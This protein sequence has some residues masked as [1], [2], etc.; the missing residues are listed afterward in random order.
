MTM[1]LLI[2]SLATIFSIGIFKFEISQTAIEWAKLSIGLLLGHHA[3]CNAGD[4]PR[5]Y[6]AS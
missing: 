6:C 3:L 2:T 5:L 1:V 4:R